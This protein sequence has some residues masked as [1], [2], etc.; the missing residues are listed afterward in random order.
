MVERLEPEQ[1]AAFIDGTLPPAEREA[2][3]QRLTASPETYSE[4]LEA[5]ALLASLDQPA[6]VTEANVDA[7]ALHSTGESVQRAQVGKRGRVLLLAAPMLVAAALLV[8]LMR[9]EATRDSGAELLLAEVLPGWTLGSGA[10]AQRLGAEWNSP[11]WSVLRGADDALSRDSRAF[12]LGAR[13]AELELAAT[14]A[15]TSAAQESMLALERLLESVDLGA[16][17]TA[18]AVRL[19][20]SDALHDV[21]ARRALYAQIREVTGMSH[22]VDLGIWLE[23]ARLA[24]MG[25]DTAYFSTNGRAYSV[26]PGLREDVISA[27]S[28]GIWTEMLKVIDALYASGEE[29]DIERARASVAQAFAKLP[30]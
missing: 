17:L 15:D 26:W 14:A 4:F 10:V 22:A 19:R 5:Q 16:R 2:V 29:P 7:R 11:T 12:R 24:T 21:E 28:M 1:L 6:A 20:S 27:D 9:P 25:A 30:R 18:E 23:A 8:V 3:L 13:I